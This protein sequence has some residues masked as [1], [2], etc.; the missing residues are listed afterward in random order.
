MFHFRWE[1]M[2]WPWNDE[3]NKVCSMHFD[4]CVDLRLGVVC[5][6]T[7][8]GTGKMRT[9]A[10]RNTRATST[11][12][13]K[14]I[15]LWQ[16]SISKTRLA[17]SSASAKSFS[18][19]SA[20]FLFVRSDALWETNAL[21]FFHACLSPEKYP[22]HLRIWIKKKV[23]RCEGDLSQLSPQKSRKHTHTHFKNYS[24]KNNKTQIDPTSSPIF[25]HVWWIFAVTF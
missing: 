4:S 19:L 21:A 18:T 9:T 25:I 11:H 13:S 14:T 5:M 2:M 6:K 22:Y 7:Q 8:Q 20:P 10:N 23:K 15:Q 16:S 1:L 12:L 3:C 17:S 24:N